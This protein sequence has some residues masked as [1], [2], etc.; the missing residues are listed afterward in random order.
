MRVEQVLIESLGQLNPF[1]RSLATKPD[2][3]NNAAITSKMDLEINHPSVCHA[4]Y[5][6]YKTD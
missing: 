2:Q 1:L 5:L 6:P 4:I 3:E